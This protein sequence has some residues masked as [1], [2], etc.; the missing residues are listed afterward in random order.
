MR[1]PTL[2]VGLN[3]DG[4]Y[5]RSP[6]TIAAVH[7]KAFSAYAKANRSMMQFGSA[8]AGSGTHVTCLLL[9]SAIGVD[10][11]HVPYRSTAQAMPD[12]LA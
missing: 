6:A 10:I 2:P 5:I 4:P 3:A 8:G 7:L 11:T 9:N 1:Q 12:M